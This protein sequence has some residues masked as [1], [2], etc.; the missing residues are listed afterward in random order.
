MYVVYLAG[1]QTVE[2]PGSVSHA[3]MMGDL[4]FGVAAEVMVLKG[5]ENEELVR[6]RSAAVQG[7]GMVQDSGNGS[8]SSRFVGL[9]DQQRQAR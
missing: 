4:M 5:A 2:V 8:R 9:P 3:V 7:Y 1:G 6:F